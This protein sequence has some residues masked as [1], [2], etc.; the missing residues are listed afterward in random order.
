MI[1]LTVRDIFAA[2]DAAS[3]VARLTGMK[4]ESWMESNA[5][6]MNALTSQSLST[7]MISVFVSLSVA[8]GIASV[9]SVSVVQ[10]TREIGNPRAMGAERR[11]L[12]WVFLLQGGVFGL[13]GAL[14]GGLAGLALVCA[15]NSSGPGLF[16]IP[17]PPKLVGL[18][19]AIATV[20]GVLSAA[21]PAQRAT[22]L[23]RA[24]AIRYV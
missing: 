22:R 8:F 18:A 21:V 19:M 4:A 5:Q 6:L 7:G 14:F 9:L 24:V 10:H 2:D 1:D 20:T 23:D 16:Y 17:L 11:Q 13:I 15:F 12:L 3:R